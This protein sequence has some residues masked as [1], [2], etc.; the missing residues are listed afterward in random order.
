M[1]MASRGAFLDGATRCEIKHSGQ[2]RKTMGIRGKETTD[3]D[4]REL[5][6]AIDLENS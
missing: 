3:S 1:K 6:V 2:Q 4:D 5:E